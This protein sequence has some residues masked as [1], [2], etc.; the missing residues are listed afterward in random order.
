MTTSVI[1][2]GARTPVGKLM[3]SLKDFSGSDLGAIAIAGALEKAG[4]PSAVYRDPGAAL[5]DPHLLQRGSFATIADQAG[6]FTGVNYGLGALL[7]QSR[8][9]MD[10]P[11]IIGLMAVI[12][13]LGVLSDRLM[14]LFMTKV[15]G[16]D[17]R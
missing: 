13:G 4:V 11:L 17:V 3:G 14:L 7:L 5:S 16:M 2:A 9:T 15:L 1:V 12:G 6:E 10:T 8:D